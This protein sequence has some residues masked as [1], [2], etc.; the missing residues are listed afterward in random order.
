VIHENGSR[1]KSVRIGLTRA[2]I[3]HDSEPSHSVIIA[4][5]RTHNPLAGGSNPTGLII[6]SGLLMVVG[7]SE[8]RWGVGLSWL[9]QGTRFFSKWGELRERTVFL[10]C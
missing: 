9:T 8:G 5:L 2:E 7:K 4:F 6:F 3:Q 10:D 1:C